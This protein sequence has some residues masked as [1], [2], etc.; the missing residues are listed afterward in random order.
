L[1]RDWECR[2]G[3][4]WEG[5]WRLHYSEASYRI[6]LAL[7]GDLDWDLRR[8]HDIWVP[9]FINALLRL[10]HFLFLLG[11]ILFRLFFGL[12]L[13]RLFFGLVLFR[14]LLFRFLL[15]RLF[16]GLFLFSFGLF[17]GFFFRL[18]LFRFL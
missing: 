14:F 15:F 13:F 4:V 7:G 3:G 6:G 8:R 18:L 9:I 10:L 2:D 16:F 1:G 17:F 12:V 11:L 5:G